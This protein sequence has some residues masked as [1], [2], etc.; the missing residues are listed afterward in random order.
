MNHFS[1]VSNLHHADHSMTL[2]HNGHILAEENSNLHPREEIGKEEEEDSHYR[3]KK[4]ETSDAEEDEEKEE[5]EVAFLT[6][7]V[8]LSSHPLHDENIDKSLSRQAEKGDPSLVVSPLHL[9]A[10]HHADDTSPPP[11][12]KDHLDLSGEEQQEDQQKS[13]ENKDG[14]PYHKEEEEEED[15]D[16]EEDDSYGGA[17]IF[18]TESFDTVCGVDILDSSYRP[19]VRRILILWCIILFLITSRL[20]VGFFGSFR[21]VVSTGSL[22]LSYNL[23]KEELFLTSII[24]FV[25]TCGA[26]TAGFLALMNHTRLGSLCKV[27][28]FQQF[29]T[30][31]LLLH[32]ASGIV[33]LVVAIKLTTINLFT[34]PTPFAPSP[35]SSLSTYVGE[36][37]LTSHDLPLYHTRGGGGEE[38]REEGEKYPSHEHGN[39]HSFNK[40]AA[41][42]SSSSSALRLSLS[43][44]LLGGPLT[45]STLSDSGAEFFASTKQNEEEQDKEEGIS[46]RRGRRRTAEKE[47]SFPREDNYFSHP[48]VADERREKEKRENDEIFSPFLSQGRDGMGTSLLSRPSSLPSLPSSERKNTKEAEKQAK[49]GNAFLSL[50]QKRKSWNSLSF[51]PTGEKSLDRKMHAKVQRGSPQDLLHE[52]SK[53]R[54]TRRA[55]RRRRGREED[56]KSLYKRTSELSHSSRDLHRSIFLHNSPLLLSHSSPFSSS[57]SPFL[58]SSSLFFSRDPQSEKEEMEDQEISS[59]EKETDVSLPTSLSSSSFLHIDTMPSQNTSLPPNP[60]NSSPS[61]SPETSSLSSSFSLPSSSSPLKTISSDSVDRS[62]PLSDVPQPFL[63]VDKTD[64]IGEKD[65][66]FF[67]SSPSFGLGEETERLG[68]RNDPHPE[69]LPLISTERKEREEEEKEKGHEGRRSEEDEG[70][71]RK[72]E[73]EDGREIGRRLSPEER[74][75]DEGVYTPQSNDE[76]RFP[77]PAISGG[78]GRE[79]EEEE[80]R[81]KGEEV[82]QEDQEKLKRHLSSSSLLSSSSSPQHSLTASPYNPG[83]RENEEEELKSDSDKRREEEEDRLNFSSLSHSSRSLPFESSVYRRMLYASIPLDYLAALVHA[84]CFLTSWKLAE[85]LGKLFG[86]K[87][88]RIPF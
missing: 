64:Q 36:G 65:I 25:L 30:W 8:S 52:L 33:C 35:S 78:P 80:E 22:D 7:P 15:D 46:P 3:K 83:E 67:S 41:A 72:E 4:K 21:H 23:W 1:E 5:E 56:L 47:G 59:G 40:R 87:M 88:P 44:H 31:C 26:T 10:L 24:E 50:L 63:S 66:R 28:S 16:E 82:D 29:F 77:H 79:E 68:A 14:D 70:S 2:Q 27:Q 58:S 81:R 74:N 37:S 51:G 6:P 53:Y 43:P 38:D 39:F 19:A 48:G 9:H 84:S 75:N 12:N 34:L 71:R 73:E 76:K 85:T 45:S 17:D 42:P 54:R 11:S 60:Q 49:D 61:T 69:F 13:Y 20:I 86:L 32:A 18:G 57:S 62:R 55:K